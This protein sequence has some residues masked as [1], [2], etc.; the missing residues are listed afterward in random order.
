MI[1]RLG[2]RLL[3]WILRSST[4]RDML[5]II[6]R[7]GI[8]GHLLDGNAHEIAECYTVPGDIILVRAEFEGT[9][10]LQA[11]D[12]THLAIRGSQKLMPIGPQYRES[13]VSTIV[14]STGLP[15]VHTANI[16]ELFVGISA[17][18]GLRLPWGWEDRERV[19]KRACY[20]EAEGIGYDWEFSSTKEDM[21]CS[22][23]GLHCI[24]DI[25]PDY[26]NL[27]DRYGELTI[28]PDDFRKAVEAGKFKLL[29]EE[30][31]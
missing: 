19:W 22:E 5:S 7:V 10:A 8:K 30:K 13:M 17:I 27:R 4:G 1:S 6:N 25:R 31:A 24:N 11:S 15:G 28:T 16:K 18:A 14:H 29:F 9:T 23:L 3:Y 20:Y 2:G 21:Y 12:Y 26:L